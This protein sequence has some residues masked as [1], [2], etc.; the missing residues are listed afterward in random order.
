MAKNVGNVPSNRI[1]TLARDQKLV[2]GVQSRMAGLASITLNN[3]AMTPAQVVQTLQDRV[4]SG[5]TVETT[6]AAWTAAVQADQ[7]KMEA[8]KQFVTALIRLILSMYGGS[9]DVLTAF[10]VSAPKPREITAE[11]AAA[12]AKKGTATKH[13]RYPNGLKG[14]VKAT[15]PE[16]ST[17]PAEQVNPPAANPN[18]AAA[19]VPNAGNPAPKG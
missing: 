8:T 14:V 5:Q 15:A 6:H 9:P 12:A 19:P 10:G 17:S 7:A 18:P 3:Q 13:S 2:A 4:T 1:A 11:K 16:Q